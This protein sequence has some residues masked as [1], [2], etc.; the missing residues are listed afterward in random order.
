MPDQ[1][2]GG[3]GLEQGGGQNLSEAH[4]SGSAGAA[5]P[6]PAGRPG[7]WF[8]L[9]VFGGLITLSLPVS[10]MA[11]RPSWTGI[12]ELQISY[13]TVTQAMYLGGGAAVSPS[14]FPLGWY[15]V[16][17]LLVG[18]PVTAAWNRWPGR[19]AGSRIPL[20]R[21]LAGGLT[22]VAATAALPLLA[23]GIPVGMGPGGPGR[24]WMWLDVFWRLGTFALLAVAVCLGWLA[25]TGRS[26]ALAVITA[27]YAIAV[28]V[29][30]WLEFQRA[31]VLDLAFPSG[32]T[33]V[34]LPAAILLLAG[35]GAMLMAG[36]RTLRVRLAARPGRETSLWSRS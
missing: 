20:A 35:S 21:Y 5:G 23:W 16:G 18:F 28:C 19:P 27:S 17:M 8:P 11:P 31:S 22:L 12:T 30:G 32:D 33:P 4:L 7:Y 14:L 3:N 24:A 34:R 26:R 1:Q 9:L 15:W 36:L 29:A 10:M 2:P 13:A 25:W 6:P